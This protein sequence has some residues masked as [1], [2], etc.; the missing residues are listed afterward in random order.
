MAGVNSDTDFRKGGGWG[1]RVRLKCGCVIATASE[2]RNPGSTYG[3]DL[4]LG[5][6]YTLAWVEAWHTDHPE[7]KR[8]NPRAAGR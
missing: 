5:H 1:Y 4:G 8:R 7:K 3:C 2:P 6:G